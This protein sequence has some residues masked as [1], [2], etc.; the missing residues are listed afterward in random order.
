MDQLYYCEICSLMVPASQTQK[1]H[2]KI[3]SNINYDIYTPVH[4]ALETSID[5]DF[6]PETVSSSSSQSNVEVKERVSCNICKNRMPAESL[7]THI[8]RKH[9]ET[10]D[11][12][13]AIGNFHVNTI[14]SDVL[15]QNTASGLLALRLNGN[16]VS[17]SV[18]NKKAVTIQ[19]M[20]LSFNA[21]KNDFGPASNRNTTKEIKKNDTFY[22]IRVS[23]EQMQQWLDENRIYAK[24]G[25]FYL[26]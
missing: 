21:T 5:L 1:H 22:S 11:Q 24:D 9:S 2:A 26:K 3:H 19:T 13:D 14:S 7:G 4:N 18:A 8:Q 25:E 12:V 20:D 17:P 15:E 6:G 10:V 16:K 23:V